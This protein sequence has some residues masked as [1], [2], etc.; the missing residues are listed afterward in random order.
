[1]SSLFYLCFNESHRENHAAIDFLCTREKDKYIVLAN[2]IVPKL[3]KRD[4]LVCWLQIKKPHNDAV[5]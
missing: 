2:D 5:Q 3:L 1:M 4:Q